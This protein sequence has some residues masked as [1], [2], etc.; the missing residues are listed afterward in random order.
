MND[1]PSNDSPREDW[2][3][4]QL[5]RFANRIAKRTAHDAWLLGRAFTFAKA[6][7]KAEGQKIEEWRKEWLPFM[8]QPTLSRYEAVGK[9]TEDEVKGKGLTEVY[10]LLELVPQKPSEPA[11]S[12]EASG[13]D[14]S[15][16]VP[17]ADDSA[18]ETPNAIPESKPASGCTPKVVYCEPDSVLKRVATVATLVR[19][20]LNDLASLDA[21]AEDADA[22]DEALHDA[23][24]LLNRLRSSLGRKKVA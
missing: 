5:G 8:S 9:L 17:D 23:I 15:D 20:V 11:P 12:I 16:P 13:A 6:K 4:D 1:T 22:L 7:A 18:D 3:L 24:D 21:K 14:S 19:S 10:R 2:S